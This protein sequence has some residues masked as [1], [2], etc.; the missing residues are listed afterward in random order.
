MLL[1]GG[2]CFLVNASL[3]TAP[4]IG[5][6]LAQACASGLVTLVLERAVA[7]GLAWLAYRRA[8][9]FVLPVA[10]SSLTGSGLWGLHAWLGTPAIAATIS[11]PIAVAWM[12]CQ[13]TSVRL[14]RGVSGSRAGPVRP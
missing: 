9:T 10:L 13:F 5:L 6:A 14:A 7:R 3:P 1:W 2:W 8:A 11:P 12:F 4:R